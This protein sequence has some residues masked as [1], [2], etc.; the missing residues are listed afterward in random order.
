MTTAVGTKPLSN[1]RMRL[2]IQRV[3][4][5]SVT[6]DGAVVGAIG[7]GLVVLCGIHEDDTDADVRARTSVNGFP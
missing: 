1:K 2:I 4:D 7:Q 6:V 5:A 3:A